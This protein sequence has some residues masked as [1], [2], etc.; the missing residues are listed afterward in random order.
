MNA[1]G[2]GILLLLSMA[3]ALAVAYRYLGDYLYR[4]VT[5]GTAES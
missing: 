2:A 5:G 1:T 3:T 4:V